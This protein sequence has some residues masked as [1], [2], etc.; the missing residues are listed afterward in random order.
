MAT[1]IYPEFDLPESA[2]L[3]ASDS[4]G[5]YIPKYFAESIKREYISNIDPSDLDSLTMGPDECEHYWDTWHHVE[6]NAVITDSDGNKFCLY[7]DGD[8]WLFPVNY[9]FEESI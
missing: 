4:H 2:I 9:E 3:Y 5:I 7:Q 1:Y 6:S 8:L